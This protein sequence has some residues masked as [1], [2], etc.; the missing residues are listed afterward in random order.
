MP[1]LLYLRRGE[2]CLKRGDVNIASSTNA[3][4]HGSAAVAVSGCALAVT[5]RIAW[6]AT[7]TGGIV[8]LRSA[9]A[10]HAG[11]LH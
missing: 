3:E 5:Q 8:Q 6:H 4:I 2:Q 9:R 7:V 11:P 10:G 1:K